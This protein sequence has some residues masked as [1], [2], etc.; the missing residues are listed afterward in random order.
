MQRNVNANVNV[1]EMLRLVQ[2]VPNMMSKI[3]EAEVCRIRGFA[4]SFGPLSV[5]FLL[6]NSGPKGSEH[7]RRTTYD[8]AA[9][10]LWAF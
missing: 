8:G 7:G 5:R 6:M 10:S 4:R 9:S 1:R 3:P 2:K